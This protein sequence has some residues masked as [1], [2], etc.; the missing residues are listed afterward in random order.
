[1]DDCA[2]EGVSNYIGTTTADILEH[3]TAIVEIR[4]IFDMENS[5]LAD[6]YRRMIESDRDAGASTGMVNW[7]SLA[8]PHA[9][10]GPIGAQAPGLRTGGDASFVSEVASPYRECNQDHPPS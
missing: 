9:R 2:V 5:A 7:G 6:V 8:P 10:T 1:M 4:S 3:E